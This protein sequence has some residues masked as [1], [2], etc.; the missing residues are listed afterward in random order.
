MIEEYDSVAERKMINIGTDENPEIVSLDK[1]T[2]CKGGYFVDARLADKWSKD[3][4]LARARIW[5]HK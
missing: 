5:G 1:L 4:L 3:A 2:Y